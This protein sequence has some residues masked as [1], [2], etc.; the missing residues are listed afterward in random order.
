MI[1]S[2]LRNTHRRCSDLSLRRA[3]KRG[4]SPAR[5]PPCALPWPSALPHPSRFHHHHCQL[6]Y[7]CVNWVS[8]GALQV[9]PPLFF[10][11]FNNIVY[12]NGPFP[13][14]Q[15]IYFLLSYNMYSRLDFRSRLGIVFYISL[16]RLCAGGLPN[17][18]GHVR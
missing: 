10:S 12:S 11:L 15:I 8:I 13:Y 4:K 3:S 6:R 7:S 9:P 18:H 14:S 2:K 17:Y 5:T 16:T 1:W